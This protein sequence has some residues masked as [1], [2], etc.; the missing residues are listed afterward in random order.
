VLYSDAAIPS[1][2]FAGRFLFTILAPLGARPGF[3]RVG[4]RPVR[5]TVEAGKRM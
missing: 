4:L 5:G 2:P 1:V 3:P